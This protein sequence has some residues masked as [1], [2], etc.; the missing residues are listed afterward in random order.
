MSPGFPSSQPSWQQV[1]AQ[2]EDQQEA[3]SSRRNMQKWESDEELGDHATISAVLY[4]NM[5]HPELKQQHPG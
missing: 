1:I 2:D 3:G 5:N 4:C